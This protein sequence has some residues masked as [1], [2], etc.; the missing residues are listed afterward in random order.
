MAKYDPLTTFLRRQK[1]ASAQLSFRD[2]E[3]MVG[4]ILPK[5]AL[6]PKWWSL[7]DDEKVRPQTLTWSRLGYVANADI[8][9]E[10]VTF[11]CSLPIA[12]RQDD[13]VLS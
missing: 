7:P 9:R 6:D 13:S 5:S 10:T 11:T 12:S 3:R 2:I 4:G 1:G 8:R